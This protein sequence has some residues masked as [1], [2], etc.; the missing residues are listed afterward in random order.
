MINRNKKYSCAHKCVSKTQEQNT[1]VA[2]KEQ[3]E[4]FISLLQLPDPRLYSKYIL[5]FP[6][7]KHEVTRDT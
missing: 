7:P 4:K 2:S 1:R 6:D 3:K 5:K